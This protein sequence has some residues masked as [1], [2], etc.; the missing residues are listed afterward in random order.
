MLVPERRDSL[1]GR[2]LKL[3]VVV[4]P[5]R[6]ARVE[7]DPLVFFNGGPG[8]ST[9]DAAAYASWALDTLRHT[10]D[11]VLVDMRGTG[12]DAPLACDLYD[13]GGRIAPYVAPMFP[14]A[15]VRECAARLAARA[16]AI[17]DRSCRPGIS[18][19]CEPPSTST[20]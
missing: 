8:L 16:D 4:L 3:A 5:A 20:A 12:H 19:T 1:G 10:R 17:H 15:R 2:T 18:T 11:V 9:T 14:V 7:P 6:G 13:D